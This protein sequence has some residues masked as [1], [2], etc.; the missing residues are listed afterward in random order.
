MEKRSDPLSLGDISGLGVCVLHP[1]RVT[2][3]FIHS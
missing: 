3:T 2:R 1:I